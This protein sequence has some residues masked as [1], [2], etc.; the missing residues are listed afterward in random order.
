MAD[1][2]KV[3]R[4][5]QM[6]VLDLDE[7]LSRTFEY[8]ILHILQSLPS[9]A[10]LMRIK[11]EIKAIVRVVIWW[12]SIRRC[13]YTFGQEMMGLSYS[14]GTAIFKND[15]RQSSLTKH[16]L[17]SV[18]LFRWIDERFEDILSPFSGESLNVEWIKSVM[19]SV[20]RFAQCI[21][22]CL[23]LLHGTYPSLKER[24]LRLKMVPIVRQTLRQPSYQFMNREIIWYGFSEMLF[25]VL[26]MIN[27]FAL[28]N[29]FRKLVTSLGVL[30]NQSV[31][32]H[33]Q[34]VSAIYQCC[35]CQ[36]EP[37][38]IPQ[39]TNNC[40]HVYCYYCIAANLMADKDYPCN[41][42]GQVVQGFKHASYR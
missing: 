1:A 3:L 22:V 12:L 23:F 34:E 8:E 7:E 6:D 26:P 11:P 31:S 16:L 13:G 5:A 20:F 38:V 30:D 33:Q 27:F 18:V 19:S 24:L 32:L 42:C 2:E 28:R 14:Q 15:T 4:V 9:Y 41:S 25:F 29:Y 21:N 39:I 10:L 36:S 35:H 40:D 17:L 37:P